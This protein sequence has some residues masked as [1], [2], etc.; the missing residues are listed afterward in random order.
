MNK[1]ALSKNIETILL[2]TPELLFEGLPYPELLALQKIV[3]AGGYLKTK[4][5][6][7]T[8][9]LEMQQLVQSPAYDDLLVPS[10]SDDL[11]E[12]AIPVNLQ[13]T[14]APII[15]KYL[16]EPRKIREKTTHEEL[17]TY[18]LLYLLT[19]KIQLKHEFIPFYVD[20]KLCIASEIVD[21][22]YSFYKDFQ[23]R[24][25]IDYAICLDEILR[26]AKNN[27]GA[28]SLKSLRNL[29]SALDKK[30]NGNT[31][32]ST[33]HV[34]LRKSFMPATLCQVG[35]R[36][37]IPYRNIRIHRLAETIYARVVVERSTKSVVERI[38]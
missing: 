37:P 16:K 2:R 1:A 4:E 3:R 27:L 14:L 6:L 35:G 17:E 38:E 5:P 11:F 33:L 12:Y 9:H 19:R 21:D 26:I 28:I 15:D 23:K 22:P 32:I 18:D 29:I 10:R 24:K 8:F 34:T 20:K 36:S 31:V 7:D 13:K 30:N 25:D